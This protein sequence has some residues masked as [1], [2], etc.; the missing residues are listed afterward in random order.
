MK[1]L[2][3]IFSLSLLLV[4]TD[5]WA[6]MDSDSEEVSAESKSEKSRGYLT[7]SFETNTTVYH[8]DDKTSAT[9]PD[10]KFGSNNYLNLAREVMEHNGEQI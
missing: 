3:L 7:G 5:A 2:F 4:G 8:K 1:Y 10:S 6:A 9:V